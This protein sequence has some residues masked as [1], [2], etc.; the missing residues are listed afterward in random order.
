MHRHGFKKHHLSG[1]KDSRRVLLRSLAGDLIQRRS[2]TTSLPKAKAVL[3]FVERLI[4]KAK[5]GGLHQR[6]QVI[7]K[8]G[9]VKNAHMLVDR[10]APRL[11]HRNSGHLRLEKLS[12]RRGD[13]ALMAR[14]SFVDSL[15][16]KEEAAESQ[17]AESAKADSRPSSQNKKPK[18]KRSQ[19]KKKAPANSKRK[20]AS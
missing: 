19:P 3:P 8:L 10:W 11:S 1:N 16:E 6:R 13:G 15:E 2:L 9:S 17:A 5:Q 7:A 18:A 20:A 12:R 14:V 4:T